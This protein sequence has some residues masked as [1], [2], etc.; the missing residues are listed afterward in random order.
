MV[1][2]RN[3]LRRYSVGA[4]LLLGSLLAGCGGGRHRDASTATSPSG[5]ANR[6]AIAQAKAFHAA[7]RLPKGARADC[8]GFVMAAYREAGHPLV[9]PSDYRKGRR[10]SAMLH[11]WSTGTRRAF[12]KNAPAPGDLVFFRDTAGPRRGDV[13]HVGLVERV[14]KDGT[15]VFLHH[16]GGRIRRDRMNVSRP[17]DPSDNAWLRRTKRKGTPALA[18]EL[19]VAYARF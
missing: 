11:E 7:K 17:S 8:S 18:G 13:T 9:I 12:R 16:M 19:F 15:V 2:G 3:R 5:D 14:E 6:A 1:R 4:I 10:V